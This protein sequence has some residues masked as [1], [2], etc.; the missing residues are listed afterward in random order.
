M[1][2]VT[3][4]IIVRCG[5]VVKIRKEIQ[6]SDSES[7]VRIVEIT[8]RPG[9][10]RSGER[11]ERQQQILDVAL[12]EMIERGYEKVTMLGIARRAG[13]S[14][15]TLY[16]WFGNRE[17]LFEALIQ[18]G[19]DATAARV[20]AAIDGGGD[21]RETL[22]AFAGG[23]LTLLTSQQSVALNRAAMSSPQLAEV[24]L[25]SG[26]NRVG[27]IVE[28]YLARLADDGFIEIDDP[29]EAFGLLYGLIIQDTQIQVLLGQQPP[30]VAEVETRASRAVERFLALVGRRR[31]RRRE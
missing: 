25:A 4:Q 12:Q 24:L 7:A 23:L 28:R 14:K 10:P 29:A 26:R 19:A 17:G 15:E 11:A 3:A 31:G 6:V 30:S 16:S 13:A 9:R 22:T 27:P 8:S 21:P 1:R 2:T 5:T 20:S 18:G